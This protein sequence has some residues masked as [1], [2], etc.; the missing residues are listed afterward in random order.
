MMSVVLPLY[1]EEERLWTSYERLADVLEESRYPWE[2]IFVDEASPDGTR[3]VVERIVAS[4]S[5]TRAIYMPQHTGRGGAAMAGI[6]AAKG[7][8]A[9]LVD[10]D[11]DVDASIIPM[12]AQDIEQGADVAYG[13]IRYQLV[14]DSLQPLFTKGWTHLGAMVLGETARE[15]EPGYELFRRE[16]ILPI[17][18]QCHSQGWF[19]D[20]ELITRASL[21]GLKVVSRPVISTGRHDQP[22]TFELTREA[23]RSLFQSRRELAEARRRREEAR[24]ELRAFYQS[25]ASLR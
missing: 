19:F 23:I 13:D 16:R 5:R 12:M 25:R 18:A 7:Q 11:L 24:V 22:G 20:T 2:M 8:I 6:R 4:D 14:S 15:A 1:R 17:V 9:G 3:E 10:V 21:A